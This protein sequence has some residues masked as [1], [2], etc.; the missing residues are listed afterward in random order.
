MPYQVV[1]KPQ[2]EKAILELPR[3]DQENIIRE[4]R[5]IAVDPKKT[6]V[7]P[8]RHELKGLWKSRVEGRR[9]EISIWT[10]RAGR[11]DDEDRIIAPVFSSPF[12]NLG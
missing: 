3:K 11:G 4:I 9:E 5:A 6:G 8:L 7:K 1:I 12:I 2:A 10:S